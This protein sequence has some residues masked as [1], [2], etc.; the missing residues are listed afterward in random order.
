MT[1]GMSTINNIFQLLGVLLIFIFVLAVTYWTTRW[2]AKYQ[3]A[4]V[5]HK[6]IKPI[7]TFRVTNGKFIQILKVGEKY[8]VVA[9]CKDTITMLTE[10]KEDEVMEIPLEMKQN[11]N[12]NFQ[13]VL[14][15]IKKKLHQKQ[16]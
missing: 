5:F 4:Q 16:K 12:L 15:D 7:E 13:Q 3:Q 11:T 9:V 10:L 6:N 14:E 1:I 8:I 2:I